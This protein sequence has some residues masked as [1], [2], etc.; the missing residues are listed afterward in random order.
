MM[1]ESVETGD[2]SGHIDLNGMSLHIARTRMEPLSDS[3]VHT[4]VP[5]II[6]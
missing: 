2:V 4:L 3:A 5:S 1:K 6:Q